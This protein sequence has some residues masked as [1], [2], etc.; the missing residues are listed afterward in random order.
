VAS[1]LLDLGGGAVEEREHVLVTHVPPPENLDAFLDRVRRGLRE[2]LSVDDPDLSWRWRPQEDWDALWKRGLGPRRITSRLTVSPSWVD[3]RPGKGEL[4]ITLDP[5]MAFGTAEH[6]TTRGCLRALARYVDSGHRIADVGAGSGIL[7]IAA[8]LLGAA[9]VLAV[10]MDGP[11]CLVAQENLARNGV[12]ERVEV[13]NEAVR[14]GNAIMDGPFHGM[15]AN[16]QSGIILPLLPVFR[17]GLVPGGWLIVSGVLLEERDR[18]L[19]R[20]EAEG[21][22]FLEAEEEGEWWTGVLT[23]GELGV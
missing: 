22:R 15:V 5:G 2:I 17:D 13:R 3:H 19:A 21:W 12:Q 7:S 8:A 20:A 18:I 14:E 23:P 4:V 1:L 10:E 6:P 16:L 11:S 9:G